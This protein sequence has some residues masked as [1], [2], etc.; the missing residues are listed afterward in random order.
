[1]NK[2]AP[3]GSITNV[4]TGNSHSALHD[5]KIDRFENLKSTLEPQSVD[6]E[7]IMIMLFFLGILIR[8][9]PGELG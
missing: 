1:M 6:S 3:I 8:W 4:L 2:I 7:A 9:P 5:C